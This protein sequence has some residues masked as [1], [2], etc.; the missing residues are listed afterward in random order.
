[1]EIHFTPEQEAQVSQQIAAHAGT[2]VEHLVKNAA[3]R[4]VE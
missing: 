4:L 2:D 3:L 1:M